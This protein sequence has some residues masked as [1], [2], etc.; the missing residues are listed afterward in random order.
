MTD[1]IEGIEKELRYEQKRLQ[2]WRWMNDLDLLADWPTRTK[3]AYIFYRDPK[4][5]AGS[6]IL[7]WRGGNYAHPVNRITADRVF[8]SSWQQ[9]IE[10]M[11]RNK[12]TPYQVTLWTK[13]GQVTHVHPSEKQALDD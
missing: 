5:L 13:S 10:E 1:L 3:M 9:T 2:A 7:F 6:Y 12:W 11:M 4:G 8:A